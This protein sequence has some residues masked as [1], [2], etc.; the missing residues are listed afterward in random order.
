MD[1]HSTKMLQ[2]LLAEK[3]WM[4]RYAIVKAEW[5]EPN[6]LSRYMADMIQTKQ[7]ISRLITTQNQMNR[8]KPLAQILTILWC[9]Q[10]LF[11]LQNSIFGGCFWLGGATGGACWVPLSLLGARF[12]IFVCSLGFATS[13]FDDMSFVTL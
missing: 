6:R 12:K 8:M 4:F 11:V 9:C 13:H 5:S 10:S 2:Q 1:V 7:L 3:L